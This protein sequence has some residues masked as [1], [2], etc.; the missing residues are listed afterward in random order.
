MFLDQ[1]PIEN[2][3]EN[4]K[5]NLIFAYNKEVFLTFLNLLSIKNTQFSK[6]SKEGEDYCVESCSIIDNF[7]QKKKEEL[8]K[9]VKT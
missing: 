9:K 1:N 8:L 5:G 6:L 3:E 2:I 7:R 4:S